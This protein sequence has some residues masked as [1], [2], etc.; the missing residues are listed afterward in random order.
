MENLPDQKSVYFITRP[1]SDEFK[2][3]NEFLNPW[4]YKTGIFNGKFDSVIGQGASSIVISGDWFGKEAAF[5]FVEI[6]AQEH[7]EKTGDALK[8]L[9]EQ[10]S[11]MTSIQSTAGSNIVSFYGHYR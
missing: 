10:L 8:T 11:E 7:Q 3:Q 2:G 9:K 6:G 4:F 5:K 1:L